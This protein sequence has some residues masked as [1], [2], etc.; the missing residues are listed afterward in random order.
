M[1]LSSYFDKMSVQIL[2]DGKEILPEGLNELM[3]T[4]ENLAEDENP[5]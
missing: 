1:F 4:V 3:S 2:R 5:R